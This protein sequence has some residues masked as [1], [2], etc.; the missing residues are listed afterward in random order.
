MCR[1]IFMMVA[2]GMTTISLAWSTPAR[3]ANEAEMAEHLIELVKIGR[4]V[5]SE[6]QATI[7]RRYES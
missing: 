2:V 5:L 3:A 4:G 6:H 1:Q 7:N